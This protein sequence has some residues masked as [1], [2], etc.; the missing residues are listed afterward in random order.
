MK[1]PTT[2]RRSA[3]AGFRIQTNPSRRRV[4][5][6]LVALVV[7]TLPIG[8][9]SF[10]GAPNESPLL[11]RPTPPSRVAATPA[12]APEADE[13]ATTEPARRFSPDGQP[14][15]TLV[16]PKAMPID[17]ILFKLKSDTGVTVTPMGQA[18]GQTIPGPMLSDVTVEEAVQWIATQKDWV[19]HQEGDEWAIMDRA[20][21]EKNYLVKQVVQRVIRPQNIAAEEAQKAVERMLTPN[22]GSITSDARTNQVIVND[23]LP[24]VEA[25]ERTIRLLDQKVF[26]R[27]F[28][29]KHAEPEQV[30]EII[31]EYKSPPGRLELVPKMRQIIAEDTYENIQRMEVMV[32]ILDRGPEMRFY[33][34]NSFD[35]EGQR[36][37]VLRALLEKEI[38][39]EEAYLE[40]DLESGVMILMDLPNVHE[41]VKKLLERVDR[42]ARQLFIQAEIV[43]TSVNHSFEMGLDWTVRNH[44]VKGSAGS[45]PTTG[46]LGGLASEITDL[47]FHDLIAKGDAGGLT[48]DYLSRHARLSFVAVME[49]SQTQILAQPRILVKNRQTATITDGGTISYAT[50]TYYGGGGGY[51]PG[52]GYPGG[53]SYYPYTPSVGSGS[54]PTGV[55]LT[56][57]PTVMNNGLIE[58]RITLTNVTGTPVT[59]SLGSQ[60]Y[61]L[62]DT[63]NQTIDT[64]LVVPDGQTRM[65]GGLIENRDSGTVNGIPYL[66]D[67][68]I[69]GPKLFGKE[70][71]GPTRRRTL[72]MF[73]TPSIVQEQARKYAEPLDD[74]EMTPPTFY[75]Q[76][77]WSAAAVKRAVEE[78]MGAAEEKYPDF[79][80]SEHEAE[81]PRRTTGIPVDVFPPGERLTSPTVETPRPR[82]P[83]PPL[84]RL[85]HTPTSPSTEIKPPP[86]EKPPAVEKP[87]ETEFP[88][89]IPPS[90]EKGPA[91]PPPKATPRPTPR[92]PERPKSDFP[93]TGARVLEKGP[94]RLLLGSRRPGDIPLPQPPTFAKASTTGA[95][96]LVE[97]YEGLSSYEL[98]VMGAD[99]RSV[100][101]GPSGTR[102]DT[103]DL[104][105]MRIPMATLATRA[106]PVPKRTPIRRTPIR[107]TPTRATPVPRRT[108]QRTPVVTPPRPTPPPPLGSPA[109]RGYQR[110]LTP[111][112]PR[113]GVRATPRRRR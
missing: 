84:L 80:F 113:P 11:P 79:P 69:I 6:L 53:S 15:T 55:T 110:P 46:T 96:S 98:V 56:V 41:K 108:P 67:I 107:R 22:V 33:D 75:E 2:H 1:R 27:V 90:P 93:T 17:T 12:P 44:A 78:G 57:D 88:Q 82:K 102:L 3:Y 61:T 60:D 104:G 97:E 73:I 4:R 54:V 70:K 105:T 81:A 40:F 71:T 94:P 89:Q 45:T 5:P 36:E 66:K 111:Y 59:R 38:L 51:Y 64:V 63:S 48:L 32:D 49:D 109:G 74:D 100:A 30:L 72:L 10:G 87:A 99:G 58:M 42:P 9:L 25:I 21:F 28:T 19:Y 39:T 83:A 65:I 77:S 7:F 20:F 37:E 95:K 52:A 29:I 50:T 91:A 92:P 101:A 103:P 26:L 23:L 13:E 43:E 14:L 31:Q 18:K 85:E 62:V 34:L 86:V 106:T 47:G 35:F 76:V 16:F 24:V 112:S 8:R 68:P